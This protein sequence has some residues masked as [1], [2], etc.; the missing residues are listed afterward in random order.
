MKH[1][2]IPPPKK[3]DFLMESSLGK[4][5]TD[6]PNI[7]NIGRQISTGR[8]SSDAYGRAALNLIALSSMP[9]HA[10]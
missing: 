2:I 9:A 7:A 8:I 4:E 1:K 6:A 10:H 5:R 3:K